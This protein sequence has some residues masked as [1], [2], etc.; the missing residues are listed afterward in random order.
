MVDRLSELIE[1]NNRRQQEQEDRFMSGDVESQSPIVQSTSTLATSATSSSTT[2]PSGSG[3]SASS[4]GTPPAPPSGGGATPTPPPPA[5]PTPPTPPSDVNV[6][7]V[8]A[9]ISSAY[10]IKPSDLQSKVTPPKA[11]EPTPPKPSKEGKSGGEKDIMAVFWNMILDAYGWCIDKAVDIPLDFISWVLY[12]QP[13]QNDIQKGASI[14]DI[15]NNEKKGFLK[16]VDDINKEAKKC[17]DEIDKNVHYLAAGETASWREI[18]TTTPARLNEIRDYTTNV[19]VPSFRL[20]T[21]DPDDP[22]AAAYKNFKKL[23]EMLDKSAKKIQMIG[24]FA[25]SLAALQILSSENSDYMPEGFRDKYKELNKKISSRTVDYAAIGSLA[26]DLIATIPAGADFNAIRGYFEDIR[27]KAGASDKRGISKTIKEINKEI[28]DNETS[29]KYKKHCITVRSCSYISKIIENI[30]KIYE[31]CGTDV[32]KRNETI[33][34]YCQHLDD[35]IKN[36]SQIATNAD[37]DLRV[38]AKV[39]KSAQKKIQKAVDAVD[40]FDFDGRT[41]GAHTTPTRRSQN[42][43]SNKNVIYDFMVGR[44]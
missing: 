41:I 4:G 26:T 19:L 15:A 8:V 14:L 30:D 3:S 40:S 9:G 5:P 7:D 13:K 1:E 21:A 38:G 10:G 34:K 35:A 27:L 36:V 31:K 32:D 44:V 20:Y 39:G 12:A 18:S 24:S 37:E 43:Y 16:G 28:T 25:Y 29:Q 2:T 17:F 6:D 23:P 22:G 11:K 33:M 42:I